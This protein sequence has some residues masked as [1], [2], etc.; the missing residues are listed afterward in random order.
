VSSLCVLVVLALLA[1]QEISGAYAY[2]EVKV[3]LIDKHVYNYHDNIPY[4]LE[5]TDAQTSS[6]GQISISSPN[7]QTA[8]IRFDATEGTVFFKVGR[9]D[10]FCLISSSLSGLTV[11]QQQGSFCSII[12]SSP[13]FT[14][15]AQDSDITD[16]K[17]NGELCE[18]QNG[19][20]MLFEIVESPQF[21]FAQTI[22]IHGK[23]SS[24][25]SA[26]IKGNRAAVTQTRIDG[27][28]YFNVTTSN[29][30]SWCLVSAESNI[31]TWL[32]RSI[33]YVSQNAKCDVKNVGYHSFTITAN[34]E[35]GYSCVFD[36]AKCA[37]SS[38]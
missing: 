30:N 21:I 4:S 19:L 32:P 5:E 22:D 28:Y 38:N 23:I 6:G 34:E 37:I 13:D 24:G 14:I 11:Y 33:V 8:I 35:Q 17:W 7:F 3:S 18:K 27:A 9:K 31:Y 12:T 29:Y 15:E 36:G 26:D 25:S 20:K 2:K 10:R 16:C 1:F